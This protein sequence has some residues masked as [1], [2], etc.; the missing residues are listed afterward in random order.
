MPQSLY[1]GLER[2]EVPLDEARERWISELQFLRALRRA[3]FEEIPAGE[4][5]GRVTSQSVTA[6][7]LPSATGNSSPAPAA[8]TI[9]RK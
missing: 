4:A 7:R 2:P 6:V 5:A 9:R 3:E 8:R 1:A